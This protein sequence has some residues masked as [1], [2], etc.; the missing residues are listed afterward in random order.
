MLEVKGLSAGY[1]KVLAIRDINLRVRDKEMVCLLGPNG[2]GKSTT[3][4][5]LSGFIKPAHGEILFAG[6]P[7][8]GTPTEKLVSKGIVLVPEGR[9]VLSTMSVQENLELGAYVR[10]DQEIKLDLERMFDLFP[11]LRKRRL[12]VAGNLSGGEQQ[13]L[14][15][16]RAL[17]AR[18]KLLLLDEPSLGLAPKLIQ[19]IFEI[20]IQIR[21]Q[22]LPILLVEQNTKKA[23]EVADYA[24]IISNGSIVRE[25]VASELLHDPHLAKSYMS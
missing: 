2:A 8:Q 7:I 15:I 9:E 23:L 10:N 1:E 12:A 17:M 3:M 18:P 6:A 24:Y 13:M 25:G 5:A 11:V 22:G 20:L 19:Q 14:V 21:H 4:K 16:A